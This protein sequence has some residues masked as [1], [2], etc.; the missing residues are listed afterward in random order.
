MPSTPQLA[1]SSG[2]TAKRGMMAFSVKPEAAPIELPASQNEIHR[3]RRMGKVSAAMADG[4]IPD[5]VK[6]DPM[7]RSGWV[8]IPKQGRVRVLQVQD[9]VVVAGPSPVRVEAH[10]SDLFLRLEGKRVK[11]S[12]AV[13]TN[14]A[15][16]H[17]LRVWPPGLGK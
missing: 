5:G 11:G 3:T 10:L 2:T 12:V 4:Q 14:R 6:Y 1:N 15:R 16:G 17:K 13:S 9:V 7:A 8:A